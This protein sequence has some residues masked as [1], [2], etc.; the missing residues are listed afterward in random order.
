[1]VNKTVQPG[2]WVTPDDI[3]GNFGIELPKGYYAMA[4]KVAPE[5]AASGFVLPKSRVNVVATIRPNGNN[6]RPRVVTI[7]QD[8]L[9]L[10][11]DTLANRPEDKIAIGGLSTALL[12]VK[13]QDSQKLTLASA[14]GELRL[15]LRPHDDEERQLLAPLDHLDTDIGYND[16]TAGTGRLGDAPTFKLA[17]AKKDLEA[18]TTIDDPDKYFEVKSFTD[19]PDKAVAPEKLESIKGQ[20]LKVPV[21]KDNILTAK[22]FD[23][24]LA[25]LVALPPKPEARK[26]LLFI[27]NGGN[28]PQVTTYVDGSASGGDLKGMFLS[29]PPE[30]K[31]ADKSEPAK[32]EP[33]KGGA[34][35][36][37][38]PQ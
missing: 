24:R 34:D 10:A 27:Q 7:L 3:S 4:V 2:Q 19:V 32:P 8:V 36:K 6:S 30:D 15:V 14:Q 35:D 18:G 26:H 5:T 38:K 22:H 28:S 9:V 12:A 1:M 31:P 17:V 16:G 25:G 37:A 23:D 33:G 11:V 21:F 13:P 29:T 20:T